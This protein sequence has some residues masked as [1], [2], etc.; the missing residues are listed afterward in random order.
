M[1]PLEL[2]SEGLD[3]RHHARERVPRAVGR[4]AEEQGQV[5]AT[6]DCSDDLRRAA[7]DIWNAVRAAVDEKTSGR[8]A[9]PPFTQALDISF[10]R[11][12]SVDEALTAV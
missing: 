3:R 1:V 9:R 11:G 2:T 5:W 12:S 4:L 8:G 6:A 10:E 7:L